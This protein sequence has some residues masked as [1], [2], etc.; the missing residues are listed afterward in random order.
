MLTLSKKAKA[1]LW[2]TGA[3]ILMIVTIPLAIW[4][5]HT[6]TAE[7][8]N[9]RARCERGLHD[10]HRVIIENGAVVPKH[11]SAR[12]CDTLVITNLDK[13]QRLMAFGK[14]DKHISYDGVSEQ[15]VAQEQSLT[16]RLVS[17][18]TYLFHDHEADET[19]GTFTVSP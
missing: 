12:H 17:T 16:V 8:G 14:H 2:T 3:L 5:T 4:L 1:V 6:Q 19:S 13:Q 15:L 18:G 10:T 7:F 9:A 11:T